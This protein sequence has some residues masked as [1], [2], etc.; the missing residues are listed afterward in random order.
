MGVGSARRQ[1]RYDQGRWGSFNEL[2]EF[3]NDAVLK[4]LKTAAENTTLYPEGSDQ[5][6]ASDFYSIGMDSLL[7]E[8]AGMEPIRPYIDKINNIKDK[9]DI[10][11]YLTEDIMTG[12]GAF[13]GIGVLSDLKNSKKI[14]VYLNSG[15]IGLPERDYYVNN[16]EKSKETREKYKIHLTNLF[17]LSGV[18]EDKAAADAAKVL[19]LETQLAKSMLTKEQSRNPT[20]QYNPKTLAELSKITPSVNWAAYF[21]DLKI[22]EDTIIVTEP[23]YMQEYE[24]VVNSY[25]LDDVKTYLKSGIV[26]GFGVI[27]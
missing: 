4:V 10:Q 15:G 7:A 26:K 12:G 3:N 13:F 8:R 21:S 25:S 20:I 2:R 18:P 24:R 17:K 23:A 14:A 11:A 9:K 1:Y 19:A 6:K 16:D 27:A 5:R 22:N